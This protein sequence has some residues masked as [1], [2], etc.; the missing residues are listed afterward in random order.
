MLRI[1][2][3]RLYIFVT[4]NPVQT[5]VYTALTL[6]YGTLASLM[7][8]NQHERELTNILRMGVSP[9]GRILTTS[10]TLP[11]V[12]LLGNDQRAWIIS[13]A[14]FSAVAMIML[15]TCF[16]NMKERVRVEAT[17]TAKIPVGKSLKAL[18][19]NKYWAIA[20]ALWGMLSVYSTLIGTDLAYYCNDNLA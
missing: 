18:F 20:M 12:K 7:T 2:S 15:F 19:A 16:F 6:P 4:Y 10:C 8:R 14:I 3:R 5:V 13:A 1:C 17:Q 9:F 11:L